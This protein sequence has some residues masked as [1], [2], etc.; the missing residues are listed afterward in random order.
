MGE[1]RKLRES[2]EDRTSSPLN[3]ELLFRFPGLSGNALR[4]TILRWYWWDSRRS[5]WHS[6]V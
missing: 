1:N 4:L 5:S 6:R 2:R 3:P